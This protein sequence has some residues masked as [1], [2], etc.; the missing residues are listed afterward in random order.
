MVPTMAQGVVEYKEAYGTD[1]VTSQN[2]QY[3]LDRFYMS[4]ISIRMLLNQHSKILLLCLCHHCHLNISHSINDAA[5][6]ISFLHL[7]YI[8]TSTPK[9]DL[10]LLKVFLQSLTFFSPIVFISAL[11]FGGKVQV[12]PAHPK[13]IGSID[14]Y[15]RVTDVIKGSSLR[16]Y[17]SVKCTKSDVFETDIIHALFSCCGLKKV[18]TLI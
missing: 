3:F 14:P 5:L 17:D 2:M 15:C 12:N 8:Y 7:H 18:I 11:L 9:T 1:P 10:L 13:Q 6:W 16:L 4:R